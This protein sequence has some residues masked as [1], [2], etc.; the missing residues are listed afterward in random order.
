MPETACDNCIELLE[1]LQSFQETSAE[2]EKEYEI[3]VNDLQ[4]LNEKLEK[5]SQNSLSKLVGMQEKYVNLEKEY[6]N[7]NKKYKDLDE[8]HKKTRSKLVDVEYCNDNLENNLRIEIMEKDDALSNY[9]KALEELVIIKSTHNIETHNINNSRRI[10]SRSQS[11]TTLE[12]IKINFENSN[13]LAS[14]EKTSAEKLS[15]QF[16]ENAQ[17]FMTFQTSANFNEIKAAELNCDISKDESICKANEDLLR[18]ETKEQTPTK[19]YLNIDYSNQKH[20]CFKIRLNNES[21]LLMTSPSNIDQYN[22]PKIVNTGEGYGL[23][24]MGNRYK[25][26]AARLQGLQESFF[27][28]TKTYASDRNSS[29]NCSIINNSVERKSSNYLKPKVKPLAKRKESYNTRLN[30][31]KEIFNKLKLIKPTSTLSYTREKSTKNDIGKMTKV[32]DIFSDKKPPRKLSEAQQAKTRKFSEAEQAKTRKL[33][34][35]E[36]AKTRKI[37][38]AEQAKTTSGRDKI[39]VPLGIS[40]KS[41]TTK[42]ASPSKVAYERLVNSLT[43]GNAKK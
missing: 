4:S 42:G 27:D 9:E 37:S 39:K 10:T 3:Q 38:E 8:S 13:D 14:P 23:S 36:Q 32:R 22:E 11:S 12:L 31:T 34:E 6:E 1:E 17:S 33:S 35:A 29:F 16:K 24:S 19:H 43:N 26:R 20:E 25:I 41:V 30:E 2:I 28:R 7:L 5:E 21:P 15:D 18:T 40:R